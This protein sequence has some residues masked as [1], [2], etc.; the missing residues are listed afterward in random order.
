MTNLKC[1]Q[2]TDTR[3]SDGTFA[4]GNPGKPRGARNRATKAVEGLLEGEA[5]RL[6]RKAVEMALEGDATAL[7]LCLERI[8]PARKSTPVEFE[9]PR[10]RSAMDAAPA[11]GAVLQSVS[12]GELAPNE[13]ANVV[14]LIERFCR[15]LE[16]G[17][18]IKICLQKEP[19]RQMPGRR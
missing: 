11:V 15:V 14:A 17:E 9:L 18:L 8:A 1:G 12:R 2:N 3:N 10:L 4:P 7:R 13:G 5:E 16:T 19:R 6:T